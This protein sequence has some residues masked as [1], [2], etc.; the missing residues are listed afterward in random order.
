MLGFDSEIAHV[1]CYWKDESLFKATASYHVDGR[2]ARDTFFKIM[3]SL[4]PIANRWVVAFPDSEDDAFEFSA[5]SNPGEIRMV[6]IDSFS[7]DVSAA[8]AAQPD[9]GTESDQMKQDSTITHW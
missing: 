7:V 4:K 5:A 1:E 9:F 3:A 6:G 8:T 2:N